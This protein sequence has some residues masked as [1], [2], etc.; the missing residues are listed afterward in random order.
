MN[1]AQ[2]YLESQLKSC[3][4]Y[5]LTDLD[6]KT[7]QNKGIETYLFGKISSKQFR[8]IQLA[9]PCEARVHTAIQQAVAAQ[10]PVQLVHPAGGYKLWSYPSF[11]EADWAEYFNVAYL[12]KYVSAVAAAYA[13]GVQISYY[14]FTYLMQKSNN[15][16]K[17]E[18]SRYVQSFQSIIDEFLKYTPA[19]ITIK[20]VCDSDFYGETEYFRMLEESTQQATEFYNSFTPERKEKYIK[21]SNTNI[22]WDGKEDWTKL[23][24]EEKENKIYQ[25][26]LYEAKGNMKFFPK[27]RNWIFDTDKI[28]IFPQGKTD[29]VGIGSTKSSLVKHWMGFGVLEKNES[30]YK[31]I[32]LSP[33]QFK[34]IENNPH[35]LVPHSS[36]SSQNFKK[37]R[38]Y[39]SP[40]FSR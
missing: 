6:R 9:A 5:V 4:H 25:G 27:I 31:E 35:E 17:E 21:S 11:P 24:P 29:F 39:E 32:I 19:N 14:L 40:I 7:I 34:E 1:P 20:L 10:K 13:P 15:L 33:S 8:K 3:S 22:H 16:S 18:V 38:V 37:I 30:G 23:S 12:L 28:I 26:A 2:S 36:L